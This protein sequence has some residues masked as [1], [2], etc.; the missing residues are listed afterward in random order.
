MAD[1]IKMQTYLF[2]R[3]HEGKPFFYPVDC[4]NDA[5]VL[6]HVERNPGTTKVTTPNGRVVWSLQ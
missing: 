1:K 6:V 5:D 4:W 2:H 3:M